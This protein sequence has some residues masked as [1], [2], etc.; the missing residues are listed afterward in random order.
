[1]KRAAFENWGQADVDAHN[2]KIRRAVAGEWEQVA[3]PLKVEELPAPAKE[4]RKRQ[5]NKTETEYGYRLSL[6]FPGCKIVFEGITL[7]LDCGAKY[8]ADWCTHLP[9]GK[10]LLCEVKNSGYKHA[11]HGRSRLAFSQAKIDF[12]QFIFRWCS[13]DKTGWSIS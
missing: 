5:P 2:K 11:S 8:T 13:K 9:D 10:I 6:E 7:R 12:P 1:M 3:I 4:I